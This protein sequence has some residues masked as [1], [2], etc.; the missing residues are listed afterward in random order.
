L[1]NPVTVHDVVAEVQ[2]SESG[3]EV[4]VYEEIAAPLLA[5]A[6]HDTTDHSHSTSQTHQSAHPELSKEPLKQTQ[7]TQHQY[8]RHSSRPP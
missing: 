7:L 4:T 3:E 6:V 8:Q 1:V 5:G 2:V